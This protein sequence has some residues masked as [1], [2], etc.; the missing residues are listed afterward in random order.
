ME[1]FKQ[2]SQIRENKSIFK[3][4]FQSI[5]WW[6][7]DFTPEEFRIQIKKLSDD[8]LLYWQKQRAVFPNT[9]ADFQ[10]KLVDAEVK[11]RNLKH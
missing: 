6:G 2:F 3:K 1:T 8:T 7:E 4:F 10:L 9:P 11:K 5:G